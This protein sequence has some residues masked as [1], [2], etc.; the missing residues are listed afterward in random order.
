[1]AAQLAPVYVNDTRVTLQG[2]PNPQVSKIVTCW[3]KSP[4]AIKEIY[5]LQSQSDPKGRRLKFQ[6]TIDRTA[7]GEAPV[8]LRCIEKAGP[9][10]EHTGSGGSSGGVPGSNPSNPTTSMSSAKKPGIGNPP[11]TQMT[12]FEDA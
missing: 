8:F 7:S 12:E 9:A 10:S 3:G 5:W 4:E 6:E 11:P 2:D 1:M